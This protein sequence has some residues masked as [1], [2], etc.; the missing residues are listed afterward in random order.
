METYHKGHKCN[1]SMVRVKVN[2]NST[3]NLYEA[4]KFIFNYPIIRILKATQIIYYYTKSLCYYCSSMKIYPLETYLYFFSRINIIILKFITC[5]FYQLHRSSSS[6]SSHQIPPTIFS[7]YSPQT[8]QIQFL[9][10]ASTGLCVGAIPQS[11]T[12]YIGRR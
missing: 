3:S 10:D 2:T 12:L 11:L 8:S 9:E 4:N 5:R 1:S 6:H 7:K